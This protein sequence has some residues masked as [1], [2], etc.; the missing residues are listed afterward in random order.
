MNQQEMISDLLSREF[1]MFHAVNGD[2]EKEDCQNDRKTFDM[3][4]LA[5]YSSWDPG[6]VESYY[7]DILEAERSGRNLCEEKYIHMMKSTD[8]A[9]YELLKDRLEFPDERGMELVELINRKMLLQTEELFKRYPYIS[10]AG[11]PLYSDADVWGETSIETYQRGEL[12]T[13]ST[14]TLELLYRHLCALEAN[15]VSLAEKILE[16]S[17]CSYGYRSLKEAETVAA[18]NAPEMDIE[19]SYGCS[20]CRDDQEC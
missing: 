9:R 10:G 19:I 2:E 18:Q 8:S 13:Y 7:Q 17:V 1:A 16:A 15:G 6:T 20:C 14:R 12:M 5:Q 11:R 4:R 3:M